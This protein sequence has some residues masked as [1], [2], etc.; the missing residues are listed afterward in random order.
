MTN[1]PAVLLVL[2]IYSSK[3][4]TMVILL[5]RKLQALV[6]QYNFSKKDVLLSENNKSKPCH[7]VRICNN[8]NNNKEKDKNLLVLQ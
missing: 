3:V 4:I 6:F 2:F 8:K 7:N 5:K 1:L